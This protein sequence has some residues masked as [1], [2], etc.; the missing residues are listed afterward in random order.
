[1]IKLRKHQEEVLKQA[2]GKNF[3][4]FHGCGAGKTISALALYEA[5][6]K[7]KP[8][9]IITQMVQK[10]TTKIIKFDKKISPKWL[11]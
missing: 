11:K 8:N 3:A 1:M 2:T 5:N 7:L 10:S 6:K 9:L 4:L